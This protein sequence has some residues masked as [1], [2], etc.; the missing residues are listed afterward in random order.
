MLLSG[1]EAGSQN[2]RRSRL[3]RLHNTGTS[4]ATHFFWPQLHFIPVQATPY[5]GSAT[6]YS[7]SATP[8]SSSNYTFFQF[9]LHLIPVHL[10]LFRVQLHLILDPANL[11]PVQATPYSSL[12]IRYLIP[13]QA[14]PYSCS[15]T[16]Y[17]GVSYTSFRFKLHI[18]PVHLHLIP[19]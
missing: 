14:T 11:I 16:P 17:S 4:T 8:F 12:A 10:H 13:V 9:K 18:I 19:E 2:R 1:A 3:D 6:P 7:G 15:S 5:S